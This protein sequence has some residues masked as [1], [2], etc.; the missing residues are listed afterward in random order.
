M[1]RLGKQPILDF[2]PCLISLHHDLYIF[3]LVPMVDTEGLKLNKR[4]LPVELQ[5]AGFIRPWFE[6]CG[7]PTFDLWLETVAKFNK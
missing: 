4:V 3:F 6:I 1:L 2:K 7:V 5:T